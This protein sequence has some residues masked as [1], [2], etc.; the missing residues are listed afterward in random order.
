VIAHRAALTTAKGTFAMADTAYKACKNCCLEKPRGEFYRD[1]GTS[2]GLRPFCKQCW[3]LRN[4][5]Y[6]AANKD[7]FRERDAIYQA[8]HKGQMARHRKERNASLSDEQRGYIRLR[9]LRWREHNRDKVRRQARAW[10]EANALSHRESARKYRESRRGEMAVYLR[11]YR[12]KPENRA[13]LAKLGRKRRMESPSIRLTLYMRVAIKRGLSHGSKRSRRTFALLGFS[14]DDL[15]AHLETKFKPGMDWNNYGEW[16]IDH[17][18]PLASFSFDT[19]DHPDF[20]K[21][22]GLSNLQPLWARENLS[23]GAKWDPSDQALLDA[24]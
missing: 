22:W 14:A 2:D 1:Q 12:R 13:R 24:A 9:K 5:A 20:R 10:K 8:A 6:R 3:S 19:P 18:R 17:I 11:E 4:A 23:K 15:R 7:A 16:H 21:A